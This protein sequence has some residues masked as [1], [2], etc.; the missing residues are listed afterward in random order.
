MVSDKLIQ[1]VINENQD[2]FI[3]LEEL[4]RT[5]RLVKTRRKERVTFTIDEEVMRKFRVVCGNRLKMSPI[6]E[7]LIRKFIEEKKS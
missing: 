5:G 4:D 1:K 3:A 2:L 7:D 6:V